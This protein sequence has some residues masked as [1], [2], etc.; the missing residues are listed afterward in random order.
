VKP[1]ADVPTGVDAVRRKTDDASFLFLLNH[2]QEAAEVWLP[3]P[4]RDLLTGKEHG[5]NLVLDPIEVAILKERI[6]LKLDDEPSHR[7]QAPETG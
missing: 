3:N 4:G 5:S 1:T 7:A 2:N 6:C